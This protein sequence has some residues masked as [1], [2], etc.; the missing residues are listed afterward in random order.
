MRLGH[1]A[2]VRAISHT[3]DNAETAK[4]KIDSVDTA[5]RFWPMRVEYE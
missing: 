3:S 5:S 1:G 4:S 2:I